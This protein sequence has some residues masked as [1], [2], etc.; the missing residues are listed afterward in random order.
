MGAVYIYMVQYIKGSKPEIKVTTEQGEVDINITLEINLNLNSDGLSV[1]ATAT[2]KK[3]RKNEKEE[4][5]FIV[6][7]FKMD[8]INFGKQVED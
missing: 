3:K 2:E 5:P 4:S 8:K 1:S 7:D 6:P